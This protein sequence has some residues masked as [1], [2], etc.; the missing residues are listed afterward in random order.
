MKTISFGTLALVAFAAASTGCA[1]DSTS[2]TG[3]ESS[4]STERDLT[5]NHVPVCKKIGKPREQWRWGDTRQFIRFAECEGLTPKCQ[6]VGSRSEGWYA[7]GL[8]AWDFCAETA[9]VHRVGEPCGPS[10][11]YSCDSGGSYC[12]GIPGPGTIGGTGVCASFGTCEVDADCALEDHQ[13]QHDDVPGGAVCDHGQCAWIPEDCRTVADCQDG[14]FC[15]GIPSDNS[16]KDGKCRATGHL[17]GEGL[18]CSEDVP[19]E[20]GLDCMGLSMGP[21]G[22]CLPSWMAADYTNATTY[23]TTSNVVAYGLATV[24][25]DIVV[26]AKLN[27]HNVSHWTLKLTD[28]NGV[29]AVVCGPNDGTCTKSR[30][31]EGISVQGNSR[32]DQVN[33]R[34]TLQVQGSGSPKIKTWTLHLSSRWD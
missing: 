17:P 13:W 8:I 20:P 29:V 16:T 22:M 21:E 25:V 15:V 18:T 33:G 10:I 11:G 26:Q 9:R 7:D 2:G 4:V 34:W 23:G 12:Q 27:R 31:A 14:Q 24:P 30:L 19:C 5:T 3:E 28:P 1:W 6:Y 32:D